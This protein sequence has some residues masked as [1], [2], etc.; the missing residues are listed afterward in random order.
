MIV[1]VQEVSMKRKAF[2]IPVG[3]ICCCNTSLQ[4]AL[5][6]KATSLIYFVII[7]SV[8]VL[9]RFHYNANVCTFGY[10]YVWWNWTR[11]E[12]EIDWMVLNG[13]NLPLAFT[14]QEAITQRVS[15]FAIA[16]CAAQS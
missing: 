13:V 2:S 12:R 1:P 15:K 7:A 6:L 16:Y 5:S 9:S 3:S 14:G 4:K 11:W 10:T 8:L